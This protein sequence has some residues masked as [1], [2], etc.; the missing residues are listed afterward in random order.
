VPARSNRHAVKSRPRAV[1]AELAS[2]WPNP[3]G[4]PKDSG[5]QFRLPTRKLRKTEGF[6]AAGRRIRCLRTERVCWNKVQ[7]AREIGP[8][9]GGCHS[10]DRVSAGHISPTFFLVAWGWFVGECQAKK[11]RE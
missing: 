4:S 6:I 5:G 8:R 10:V 9:H 3:F 2:D 7:I 1:P 11:L